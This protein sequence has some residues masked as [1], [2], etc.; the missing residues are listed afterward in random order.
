MGQAQS[1]NE[2]HQD[3]EAIRTLGKRQILKRRFGFWSLF[4]FATCELITWETV[5]ALLSIGLY[6]GGPAGL[7]YGFIIAWLSTLY[8]SSPS[9]ARRMRDLD[10]LRQRNPILFQF[11]CSF[12]P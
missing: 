6:N 5:L 4:A 10:I 11:D 3:R 7:V 2:L 8:V 1:G 9:L 12:A